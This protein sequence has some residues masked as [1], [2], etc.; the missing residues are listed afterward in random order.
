MYVGSIGDNPSLRSP[1]LGQRK[2]FFKDNGEEDKGNDTPNGAANK[3]SEFVL[4][5]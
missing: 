3:D 5:L 2:E 4:F 1:L